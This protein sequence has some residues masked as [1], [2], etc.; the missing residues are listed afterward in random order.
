ML[1]FL[2]RR[3]KRLACHYR[4][5]DWETS[6]ESEK[7]KPSDPENQRMKAFNKSLRTRGWAGLI[8]LIDGEVD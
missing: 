6:T 4:V 5:N 2:N 3:G 7:K 1:I 8:L